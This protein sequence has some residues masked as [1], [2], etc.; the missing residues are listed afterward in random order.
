MYLFIYVYIC[1]QVLF[2]GD[3]L[4]AS[5]YSGGVLILLALAV[6]QGL[7]FS[8]ALGPQCSRCVRKF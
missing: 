5:D 6:S 2:L 7:V 8:G 4:G 1:I 3:Q